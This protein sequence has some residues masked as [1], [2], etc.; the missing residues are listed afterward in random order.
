MG[1]TRCFS[2]AKATTVFSSKR[3]R[4]HPVRLVRYPG[5]KPYRCPTRTR[6]HRRW[7]TR[8]TRDAAAA[9]TSRSSITREPAA[10]AISIQ[11]D[12]DGSI[13]LRAGYSFADYTSSVDD[14]TTR[15][16]SS[17]ARTSSRCTRR[18]VKP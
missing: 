1:G 3:Q 4:V 15:T 13:S 9:S 18:Q 10:K 6:D 2:H 17:A 5:F 11:P 7:R 12:S 16:K 8:N 14:T